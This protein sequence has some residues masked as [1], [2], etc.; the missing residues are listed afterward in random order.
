MVI[1][2]VVVFVLLFIVVAGMDA[3]GAG[4][5]VGTVVT[6]VFLVADIIMWSEFGTVRCLLRGLDGIGRVEEPLAINEAR[7]NSKTVEKNR[8]LSQIEAAG[9][10]SFVDAG[11]GELDGGRIV[12]RRELQRSKLQVRLGADG[13]D[14][15]VVVTKLA[16]LEGRGFAAESAGPNVATC[17]EHHSGISFFCA[18]W[19]SSSFQTS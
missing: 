7:G 15:G 2:F 8:G 4:V 19:S 12:G 3:A 16:T 6:V 14:F 17:H 5:G 10:D 9:N 1:V 18:F 11:N 13:V